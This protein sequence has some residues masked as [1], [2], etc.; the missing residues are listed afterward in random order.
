MT[1]KAFTLIGPSRGKLQEIAILATKPFLKLHSC[2]FHDT[3]A[4]NMDA[5]TQ[6]NKDAQR[7][8]HSDDNKIH[9]DTLRVVIVI[10]D[11]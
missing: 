5:N 2:V 9:Y 11:H 8:R 6:P 7:A 3:S 10:V 4:D 1:A